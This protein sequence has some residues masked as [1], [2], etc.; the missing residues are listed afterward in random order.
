[1]FFEKIIISVDTG[2]WGQ[3]YVGIL[4]KFLNENFLPHFPPENI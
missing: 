2:W 1:M 4:G 3:Y